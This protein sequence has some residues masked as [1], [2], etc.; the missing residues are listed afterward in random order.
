MPNFR[1]KW[2]EFVAEIRRKKSTKK[3]PLTHAQA[4]KIA[5]ELWPKRKQ[6]LVRKAQ[7]ENKAKKVIQKV[8]VPENSSLKVPP[9][10]IPV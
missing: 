10:E 3:K 9:V 7:R 5:S 2:F 1:N 8:E 4:M 6:K